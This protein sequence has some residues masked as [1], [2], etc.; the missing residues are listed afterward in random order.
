MP[1]IKV[2]NSKKRKCLREDEEVLSEESKLPSRI[3]EDLEK[4]DDDYEEFTEEESETDDEDEEESETEDE[5][6]KEA[7]TE[8]EDEDEDEPTDCL[9]KKIKRNN[10]T[11]FT[12]SKKPVTPKEPK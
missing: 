6:E 4:P 2:T 10:K 5:D 1:R 3:D 8:T 9:M 12:I 7:E 11:E